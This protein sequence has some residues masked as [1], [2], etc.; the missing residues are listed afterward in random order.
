MEIQLHVHD[1]RETRHFLEKILEIQHLIIQKLN[2]MAATLDQIL[3]D[4]ADEST[5]IDSLATLTAGLKAQ[6]DAVLAGNLTP[7]QQAKVDAIFSAV[8]A[9]KAKVAKAVTDNT[10]AATPPPPPPTT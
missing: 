9:N 10:P 4:T 3:A 8:D 7:D 5:V 2:D 6:L 1:D